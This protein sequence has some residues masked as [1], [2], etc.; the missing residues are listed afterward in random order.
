MGGFRSGPTSASSL[1]HPTQID[2]DPIDGVQ[3]RFEPSSDLGWRNQESNQI[4]TSRAITP[5]PRSVRDRHLGARYGT[6]C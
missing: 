3:A 2:L 5:V 6:T 1:T 4:N